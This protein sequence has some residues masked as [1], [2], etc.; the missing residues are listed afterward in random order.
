VN[1]CRKTCLAL[2]WQDDSWFVYI[3]KT[4][5]N[6][7]AHNKTQ[8]QQDKKVKQR[9]WVRIT[10]G[11]VWNHNS[12]WMS[13]LH[14]YKSFLTL[15]LV[16]IMWICVIFMSMYLEGYY[17]KV[18]IWDKRLSYNLVKAWTKSWAN[19]VWCKESNGKRYC[20]RSWR[21]LGLS[22]HSWILGSIGKPWGLSHGVSWN[23]SV[24]SVLWF[25]C[26]WFTTLIVSSAWP[27][28]CVCGVVL[29]FVFRAFL[30]I[31]FYYCLLCFEGLGNWLGKK[32]VNGS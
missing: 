1:S 8:L 19:V 14:E 5:V 20:H 17:I 18:D 3:T 22:D 10:F 12:K 25:V 11:Y 6:V 31:L 28:Q 9:N 30:L 23:S 13:A 26:T 21:R 32:E 7:I 16:D 27:W 29:F 4:W 24:F 15:I 2:A